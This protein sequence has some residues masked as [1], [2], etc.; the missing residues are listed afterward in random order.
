MTSPSLF[1][2]DLLYMKYAIMYVARAVRNRCRRM[3]C[4]CMK[5]GDEMGPDYRAEPGI[6]LSRSVAGFVGFVSCCSPGLAGHL[7]RIEAF[8]LPGPDQSPRGLLIAP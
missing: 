2:I 4:M 7:L 3:K 1:T 6:R 8:V 5:G